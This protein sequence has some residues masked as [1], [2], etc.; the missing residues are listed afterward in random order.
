MRFVWWLQAASKRLSKDMTTGASSYHVLQETV[1]SIFLED[2]Y[3]CVIVLGPIIGTL[4]GRCCIRKRVNCFPVHDLSF[5][6]S[7]THGDTT[8]CT[9]LRR[10]ARRLSASARSADWPCRRESCF[11]QRLQ[12]KQR[13][14]G[15]L[16][17]V[18]LKLDT[19]N[20]H[21]LTLV[22]KAL[23]VK[24]GIITVQYIPGSWSN[25]VACNC[26]V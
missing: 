11:G 14:L 18:C 4:C 2:N 25:N 5:T 3:V 6:E 8:F 7:Q 15:A 20:L 22:C 12:F 24:T 26:D 21:G 9:W 19:H 13:Y 10:T 16:A 17:P 1:K 23:N